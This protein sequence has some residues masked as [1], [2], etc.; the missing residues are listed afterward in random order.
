VIPGLF[1]LIC[2]MATYQSSNTAKPRKTFR[3][4]AGIA[5]IVAFLDF[6]ADAI[7]RYSMAWFQIVSVQVHAAGKLDA[8]KQTIP[9]AGVIRRA[10]HLY[11]EHLDRLDEAG[12]ISEYLQTAEG[13]DKGAPSTDEQNRIAHA[14]HCLEQVGETHTAADGC[15]GP[16]VL[17]RFRELFRGT[18][19]AHEEEQ[20]R[21]FDA[22]YLAGLSPHLRALEL[23]ER[24]AAAAALKGPDKAA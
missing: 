17:P 14:L 18:T 5:R 11:A 12:R 3:L 2:I 21:A 4:A 22:K 15:P 1:S 7:L 24:E 19:D 9:A 16:A 13:L 20:R 8:E 23:A 10:L 6:R